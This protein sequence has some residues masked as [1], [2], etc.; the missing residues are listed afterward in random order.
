MPA[1]LVKFD[2]VAWFAYGSVREIYV[3]VNVCPARQLDESRRE[4]ADGTLIERVCTNL[5]VWEM[6]VSCLGVPGLVHARGITSTTR[7]APR[8]RA[9]RRSPGD[10]SCWDFFASWQAVEKVG[11]LRGFE[12]TFPE[13]CDTESYYSRVCGDR[14]GSSIV[15]HDVGF[16]SLEAG[17]QVTIQRIHFLTWFRSVS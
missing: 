1:S 12:I 5:E 3:H 6:T 15:V 9:V 7:A 14:T 17:R 11:A 13:R 8:L 2:Y 16:L 10:S 4:Q